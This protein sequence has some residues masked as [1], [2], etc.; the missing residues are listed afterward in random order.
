MITVPALC[1]CR[2]M[3]NA[4]KAELPLLFSSIL[5]VPFAFSRTGVLL[6]ITTMLIV[7]ACNSY[8]GVLMLRAAAITGHE[9]YEGVAGAV[10]GR[11]WKVRTSWS[12]Q[13]YNLKNYA[14]RQIP[15]GSSYSYCFHL[16]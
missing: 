7:G 2:G 14:D 5:P 6:G 9:S 3:D 4:L 10:G 12:N 8:T 1:L 15:K 11:A 16:R 13:I